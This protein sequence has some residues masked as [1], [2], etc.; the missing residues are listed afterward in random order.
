MR[1]GES[2]EEREPTMRM[3]PRWPM[4]LGPIKKKSNLENACPGGRGRYFLQHVYSLLNPI[5]AQ[6]ASSTVP[7]R[8]PRPHPSASRLLRPP[9]A[10][11]FLCC[12]SLFLPSFS[13][14]S[15]SHRPLPPESHVAFQP[16]APTVD[17]KA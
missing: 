5:H 15:S 9:P 16:L 2:Q 11:F 1:F 12:F 6:A 8:S 13:F 4:R 14:Y 7:S 17:F 10:S 3:L